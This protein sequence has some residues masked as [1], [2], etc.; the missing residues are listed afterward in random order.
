[1]NIN[2][3][4][5]SQT[6]AAVYSASP[7]C[8][9]LGIIAESYYDLQGLGV[10]KKARETY[11]LPKASA[12][13]TIRA[14]FQSVEIGMLNLGNV[15]KRA[16]DDLERGL[17]PFAT[18]KMFW[19]RGFHRLLARLSLMPRQL[20]FPISDR[21]KC[22]VLHISDSPAFGEYLEA[23][24]A[25]DRAA[26]ELYGKGKLQL[27]HAVSD[28]SLDSAQFNLIHCARIANHEAA[29]WERNLSE[30]PVPA[31]V[32]SYEKFV[33]SDVMREAVYERVL[34]GDTYFTQF[35]G[36][37]QV[38]EILGEEMNDRLEQA[39]R[40][41]RDGAL[42]EGIE[43]LSCVDVLS[44]GVLGSLPPMVDNLA[45]ADYHQIRE[46]LGLTSG[47]HSVCL[48]FDMFTH[49]YEQ[50]CDA[51]IKHT[52]A[53]DSGQKSWDTDKHIRTGRTIT[54]YCL[55]LRAF[56]FQWRDEH[57]NLPRNNLG[58]E[59]TKSLTGSPDAVQAVKQMRDAARM[60]DPMQPLLR[61]R[62]FAA[63]S[64]MKGPLTRYLESEA[65]LDTHITSVTGR[66]TQRR[67]HDVQ[68]R[69]G[70]FANRCPFTPPA[71]RE[72]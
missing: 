38:P 30:T 59:F 48:R 1:M 29:L 21:D 20:G 6:A 55:K 61:A 15:V 17:I 5:R 12:E 11:P 71:R 8:N 33:V 49:L 2:S 35:R 32:P 24:K 69:L 40:D 7:P 31:A 37:H 22:G 70:Y 39:I 68:E 13:S 27:E 45:T 60:R 14:I 25:F 63:E 18:V 67:F 62:G 72:A 54:N 19:A 16:G 10:L 57:L 52:D 26:L 9:E 34:A 36:L 64:S 50:L 42:E 23:L 51:V 41:V 43:Q 53:P 47:S 65:S 4:E 46:N 28:E 58:G 44:E 56:I 66:I 3:R